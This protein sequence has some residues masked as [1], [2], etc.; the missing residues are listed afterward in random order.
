M[1][2]DEYMLSGGFWGL[3]EVF[4]AGKRA[5]QPLENPKKHVKR[6]FRM[7]D[8]EYNTIMNIKTNKS[9]SS[10]SR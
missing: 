2:R 9:L 5:L 1:D 10:N 7:H 8:K 6:S 4:E 3:V